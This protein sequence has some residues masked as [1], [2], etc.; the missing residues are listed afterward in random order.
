MGVKELG[1][2]VSMEDEEEDDWI[3]LTGTG[4]PT[5]G[6]DTLLLVALVTAVCDVALRWLGLGMG[7]SVSTGAVFCFV[8][9]EGGLDL[10]LGL[11]LPLLVLDLLAR[12][13]F[14]LASFVV[15]VLLGFCFLDLGISAGSSGRDLM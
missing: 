13:L 15:C 12:L 4:L 8:L 5:V 6:L 10:D 9:E 7:G 11:L 2:L 1:V 3:R 14:G